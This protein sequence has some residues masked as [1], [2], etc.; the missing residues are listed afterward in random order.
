MAKIADKYLKV[1]PWA[2]VEEGFDAGRNRVSESIFSL[3]N[4]YM[5]VRGYPEEGYGGDSLL[6]S[7][8]NGLYEEAPVGAHYRGIIRSLRFMVNAV[9]W[10]YTRIEADGETL[11]LDKSRI[12]GFNR[13]LDFET[14]VYTRQFDWHLQ[15]GAAIHITFERIVSMTHSN[16]GAQRVSFLS[17]SYEGTVKIQSGLDFSPV[18]EDRGRGYWELVRTG[19]ESGWICAAGRTANT[20]NRLFSSFAL[21]TSVKAEVSREEQN[22]YA[23]VGF[24]LQ[25]SPGK[26]L[27]YEK[28]AVN[29]AEK[30]NA[31]SDGELWRKGAALAAGFNNR[32][33]TDIADEQERYW[34][35]V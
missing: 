29:A 17:R 5:G 28:I 9:D 30:D 1:E 19:E 14:G 11:D 4:E 2:V 10:L 8:F 15:S 24:A 34:S 21:R 16:L 7:Y 35:N 32:T 26:S 33:F 27:A 18:H 25:L 13:R 3:G 12:S 23:G 31:V 22:N 6:G 20:G